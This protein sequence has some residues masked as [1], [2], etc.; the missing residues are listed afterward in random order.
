MKEIRFTI[1][2]SPLWHSFFLEFELTNEINDDFNIALLITQEL[3]V[4][5]IHEPAKK[6]KIFDDNHKLL[7]SSTDI[8]ITNSLKY[9]SNETEN[10]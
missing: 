5:G 4:M 8:T 1:A 7:A 10:P 3:K 6:V 9:E 2:N